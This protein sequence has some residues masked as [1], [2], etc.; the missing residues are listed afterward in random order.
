VTSS[1]R[2]IG[3]ERLQAEDALWAQI[4]EHEQALSES[5]RPWAEARE[6]YIAYIRRN[7]TANDGF[8]LL[9]EQNGLAVGLC[10]A[11][12]DAD[13]EGLQ[14]PKWSRCGYIQ[15]LVVRD[16]YRRTGIAQALMKEAER[17]FA[18]RSISILKIGSLANNDLALRS[19]RRFGFQP[20]LIGLVKKIEA[21]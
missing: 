17:T 16:G 18:A 4:Q 13:E 10:I 8:I 2:R 14:H 20:F 7:L 3:L 6:D 12:I 21:D 15:D 1:V 11:W 9:A 5:R 19:Y